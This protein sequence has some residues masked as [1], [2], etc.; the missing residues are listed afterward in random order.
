MRLQGNTKSNLK[1]AYFTSF[2]VVLF[3]IITQTCLSQSLRGTV[4]DE[5]NQ[6][7]PYVN[8]FIKELNSGTITNEQGIYL[9]NIVAGSYEVAYSAVGY[10]SQLLSIQ[11]TKSDEIANVTL[12]TSSIELNQ[13]VVKA[14]KRDPAYGIIQ[15]AIEHKKKYAKQLHACKTEVYVKANEEIIV[16]NSSNNKKQ[17]AEKDER[18]TAS[19]LALRAPDLPDSIARY[20]FVEINLTLNYKA[21]NF[22]KEERTAYQLYGDQTGLFIPN[23]SQ[24]NFNFYKNY[25]ALPGITELPFI[26]PLSKTAILSYKFKLIETL[27]EDGQS[28][29]KIK[30]IPRKKGNATCSGFIYIN[31]NLWNVN[32]LDIQL[33]KGALKL[34]DAFHIQLNYQKINDTLWLP[35]RQ[36]FNYSTKTAKKKSYEGSTLIAFK[37]HQLNCQ[38]EDDFFGNEVAVSNKAAYERDTLYWQQV[39]SE[40]LNIRQNQVANYRDSVETVINS[41]PYKDSVEALYNKIEPLEILW[42]GVGLQNHEKQQNWYFSSIASLMGFNIIGGFRLGPSADFSKKMIDGKIIRATAAPSIGIIHKDFQGY[43]ASDFLFDPHRQA[44]AGLRFGRDF[45][46]INLNDAYLNIIQPS[47]FILVDYIRTRHRIEL[48]NGLYLN[49]KLDYMWRQDIPDHMTYVFENWFPPEEIEEVFNEP[50]QFEPHQSLITDIKL[51]YTPAQKYITEPDRKL[52]LGSRFPTISLLY[53]KGWNRLLSS[54][55][56]FD[57]VE[58]SVEQDVVLGQFGQSKYR[59]SSG[60][61]LNTKK[62]RHIDLKRFRQSDPLLYFNPLQS[63]Q[64]LDTALAMSSKKTFVEVHHIHHFNGALIN[65]IPVVKELGIR[66]VVGGGFLWMQQNNYRHEELFAGIERTFKLGPRRRLRLGVYG[67]GANNN[68]TMFNKGIKFSLDIIDTWKRD[69]SY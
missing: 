48:V 50:L 6:P 16:P 32:R 61:Y 4:T 19:H 53:Q 44:R 68:Q 31:D 38:F 59:I 12:K 64:L 49:T 21:P 26:S 66:L 10:E 3:S 11:I 57:Y 29:F 27:V 37:Q 62:L 23:F 42:F 18:P 41:K 25:V 54:D 24:N 30:I 55:V 7:I 52:V 8:I 28:I 34:Y 67:V 1:I 5:N 33:P 35:N 63:F 17:A 39:R 45:A 15:K 14:G 56:N 2:F 69:W 13:I 40:P 36:Q 51:S 20:N 47:N 58:L 43:F 46:A 9:Y 65:N 60:T 22:Y